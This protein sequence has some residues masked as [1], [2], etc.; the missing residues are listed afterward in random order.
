MARLSQQDAQGHGDIRS[1]FGVPK[2][3]SNA[4]TAVQSYVSPRK[5]RT[6]D[7]HIPSAT[8][9]TP[10]SHHGDAQT[11]DADMRYQAS[12]KELKGLSIG[13]DR[14]E[15]MKNAGKKRTNTS[16]GTVS[17]SAKRSPISRTSMESSPSKSVERE[18]SAAGTSRDT[19]QTSKK[20]HIELNGS[21]RIAR[22][23]DLY[24]PNAE[25]PLSSPTIPRPSKRQ[26]FSHGS[27]SRKEKSAE[28]ESR[29]STPRILEWHKE[30]RP[31]LRSSSGVK[32]VTSTTKK[33]EA[34][35]VDQDKENNPVKDK[36]DLGLSES[37]LASKRSL[38][39]KG[40]EPAQISRTPPSRSQSKRDAKPS[41]NPSSP[42]RSITKSNSSRTLKSLKVATSSSPSDSSVGSLDRKRKRDVPVGVPGLQSSPRRKPPVLSPISTALGAPEPEL[43]TE[44]PRQRSASVTSNIT[45]E[46]VSSPRE[47]VSRQL[48]PAAQSGNS[49]REREISSSPPSTEPNTATQAPSL[50]FPSKAS[51]SFS[52]LLR[53]SQPSKRIV[54][55]GQE[56][57]L[58][59]DDDSDAS[60][61]DVGVLF[62]KK[63]PNPAPK[64]PVSEP[65]PKP[66]YAFSMQALL[67]EE[68]QAK[69]ADARI[70]AA[71]SRLQ[72]YSNSALVQNGQIVTSE[73]AMAC[74]V[75][76]GD[77]DEGNARRVKEAFRRTEVLD[78]HDV[79]HF[80]N[81][82]PPAR[83]TNTFPRFRISNKP[84][85][86]IL[87]DPAKRQQAFITGFLTRLATH[88]ALP[89][90]VMLWMMDEVCREPREILVQ[91]YIN[92]LEASISRYQEI[93]TPM[94]V[95]SLFKQLGVTETVFTPESRISASKEP[96]GIEKRPIIR[97]VHA[98]VT[99]IDRLAAHMTSDSRKR[100]LHLLA[101]ASFDDSVVQDC[102]LSVQIEATINKLLQV[103]PD[104]DF[105]QE[106]LDV[107]GHLFR[108]VRA[109]VLRQQL[110]QALP[111]YSSR[112]HRF[113]RQLALAFALKSAQHLESSLE[114]PKTI[115]H[116]L[117]SLQ[118]SKHFRVTKKTNW[119]VMEAY[120]S[121]LDVA[122]D[123]GFSD[124]DF[125]EIPSAEPGPSAGSAGV[126]KNPF[127]ARAARKAAAVNVKEDA[128]NDEI[129]GLTREVR[130]IMSLILDSGASDM[131]RTEC[132]ATAARFVKRLENGVRTKTKPVKDYYQRNEQGQ[133]LMK[134]FVKKEEGV[135]RRMG[136]AK[137]GGQATM[138]DVTQQVEKADVNEE[139]EDVPDA[140]EDVQRVTPPQVDKYAA[141]DVQQKTPPH[142]GR[143]E[144]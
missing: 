101:L 141:S 2:A 75:E 119:T 77:Q 82:E 54:S 121:M 58:G 21:P 48:W 12:N 83:T 14:Y 4:V 16:T 26:K 144:V 18:S 136:E 57:V 3:V 135:E 88:T 90:E 85:A 91:S 74:L 7:P 60:L 120:F 36:E 8:P 52:S 25:N 69:A 67:Q 110:I 129:D 28:S 33:R 40:D 13:V 44:M 1:W 73:S 11:E 65:E 59:S 34:S 79:W 51:T 137:D 89:K 78:Y 96:V 71:K 17:P 38:K 111:C 23:C 133:G 19:K 61:P 50:S 117:L 123:S 72:T 109:A 99:L 68:K 20:L 102:H 131:T 87:N 105:E 39:R 42:S 128:F 35:F 127:P 92:V 116:V 81:E 86:S 30:P 70:E 103:I 126:K 76:N 43:P 104:D 80:F 84:L 9:P 93:V 62:K 31:G 56:V 132:K 22:K 115:S 122:V 100:A 95:D 24:A 107:G 45:I 98:L 53:S 143:H 106:I 6:K 112:S 41:S 64:V 66:K 124:L 142:S 139:E 130:D 138:V 27:T 37:S 15:S 49:E 97:R 10:V 125:T 46:D 63:K 113:R 47:D 94:R 108:T 55:H 32:R 134:N 29:P 5:D 118:S 140:H 114:N